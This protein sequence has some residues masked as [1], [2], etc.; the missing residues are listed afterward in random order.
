MSME[1]KLIH[2]T[3]DW[4]DTTQTDLFGTPVFKMG[5]D[6]YE[7]DTM[8]FNYKTKR[9]LIA[10]VV[11][12]Q[13]DGFMYSESSKRNSNGDVFLRKGRYTTC[14]AQHPDCYLASSRAKMRPGK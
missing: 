8:T 11:T 2:A 5:S 3:G 7:S 13:E 4:I 6:T 1:D 9:G 10:N 12:A 14:D